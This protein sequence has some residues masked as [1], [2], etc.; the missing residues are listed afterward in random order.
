MQR[1]CGEFWKKANGGK[2]GG[3]GGGP[4]NHLCNYLLLEG[5]FSSKLRPRSQHKVGLQKSHEYT[6]IQDIN[7]IYIRP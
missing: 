7:K 5:K 2:E 6:F 4:A 3:G 1:P